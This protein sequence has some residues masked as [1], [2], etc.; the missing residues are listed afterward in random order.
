LNLT[1]TAQYAL[2]VP[3]NNLPH[4]NFRLLG[5]SG[6]G[7]YAPGGGF[8]TAWLAG[9]DLGGVNRVINTVNDLGIGGMVSGGGGIIKIGPGTL[10]LLAGT[11]AG[12]TTVNEGKLSIASDE[13]LGNPAGPLNINGATLFMPNENGPILR[14]PVSIGGAGASFE[15]EYSSSSVTLTAGPSGLGVLSGSGPITKWGPGTMTIGDPNDPGNRVANTYNGTIT[16]NNGALVLRNDPFLALDGGAINVVG[17]GSL[18][19][20]HVS[21]DKTDIY[22]DSWN[23]LSLYNTLAVRSFTIIS[24]TPLSNTSMTLNSFTLG[25]GLIPSA[26]LNFRDAGGG[27][28]LLGNGPAASRLNL[29]INL[30]N[31]MRMFN[32]ADNLAA[33]DLIVDGVISNGSLRKIGGGTLALN[34]ANNYSGGT[35]IETGTIKIFADYGLGLAGSPLSLN[36]GVLRTTSSFA[37]THPVSSSNGGIHVDANTTL[38]AVNPLQGGMFSKHGAGTLVLAANT[39]NNSL[40][41]NEG[42]LVLGG[43]TTPRLKVL[44]IAGSTDNWVAVLDVKDNSLVLEG[45][46]LEVITNQIR[47]GLGNRSGIVSSASGSPYRLGS[48]YNHNEGSTKAIYTT[49][50]GID[51]L[52]GSE[53]LVRYT[54][55]GDLNL[56]GAV[57]IADF[58]NLAGHFDSRDATWQVGDVNYDGRVTIAD[59]IALAGN[60]GQSLSGITTPI[61]DED[62]AMLSSFAVSIGAVPEPGLFGLL[63]AAPLLM[64]RRRYRM[65]CM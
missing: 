43:S 19:L 37:L 46:D 58:I 52:D 63:T 57:S 41:I 21:A 53:V 4:G 8:S 38:T 59:F 6:G 65:S 3:Y 50:Q 12:G 61:R 44:N 17:G 13:S 64:L 9:I 10:H 20:E 60:F 49:F 54:L 18:S 7:I 40:G 30:G 11:Y 15:T 45:G 56:D 39:L 34:A 25:A 42:T 27:V 35:I 14:R 16:V 24:D 29:P 22:F 48:M 5:A 31:A 55:I 32:V 33:D 51:R 36:G 62:R 47:S 2:T 26:Y 23:T 1:S 28:T